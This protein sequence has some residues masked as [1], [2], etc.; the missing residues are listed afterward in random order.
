VILTCQE[1]PH[2]ERV[3]LFHSSLGSQRTQAALAL[4]EHNRIAHHQGRDANA[5]HEELRPHETVVD[6]SASWIFRAPMGRISSLLL[7]PLCN[8]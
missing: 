5:P 4:A 3:N 2:I 7:L 1:C 8:L 6:L